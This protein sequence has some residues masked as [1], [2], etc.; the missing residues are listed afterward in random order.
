[1]P[2]PLE[3]REQKFK[4]RY[5]DF[6]GTYKKSIYLTPEFREYFFRDTSRD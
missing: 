1:M 3:V 4:L 5:L 6:R 2:Y